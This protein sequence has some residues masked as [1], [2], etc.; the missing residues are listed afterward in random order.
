MNCERRTAK[1]LFM[2]GRDGILRV[3]P[4]HAI[5]SDFVQY[6]RRMCGF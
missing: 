3:V 2:E 4:E 6:H 5:P 1:R